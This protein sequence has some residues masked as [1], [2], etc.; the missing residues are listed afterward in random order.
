MQPLAWEPPYA[1]GMALK[2]LKKKKKS[3]IN[4]LKIRSIRITFT[5]SFIFAIT[6]QLLAFA[7]PSL[8]VKMIGILSL[9]LQSNCIQE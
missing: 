8:R 3:M 1:V 5:S 6:P 2:R 4:L 7:S 9:D